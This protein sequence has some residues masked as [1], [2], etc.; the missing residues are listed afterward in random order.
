MTKKDLVASISDYLST[1]N[2]FVVMSLVSQP[3]L[4]RQLA[5]F[6][7][8]PEDLKQIESYLLNE[9]SLAL[10]CLILSQERFL[11]FRSETITYSTFTQGNVKSSR[12]Q[13]AP[14]LMNYI[15]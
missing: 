13:L 14:I 1:V 2:V 12:K 6:S 4:T 8:S 3:A 5:V 7:H 10:T 11:T 9:D 15:A